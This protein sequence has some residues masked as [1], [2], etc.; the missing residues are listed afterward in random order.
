MLPNRPHRPKAS[1]R[2]AGAARR[3]AE[4]HPTPASRPRPSAPRPRAHGIG[5]RRFSVADPIG[6]RPRRA[7]PGRPAARLPL[8]KFSHPF[9]A[10]RTETSG[11]WGRQ[12]TRAGARNHRPGASMRVV[13]AARRQAPA[14]QRPRTPRGAQN[15][16][17]SPMAMR[18]EA[19]APQ[20]RQAALHNGRPHLRE[21]SAPVAEAAG[22]QAPAPPTHRPPARIPPQGPCNPGKAPGLVGGPHV[23]PGP[24]D[25]RGRGGLQNLFP[26]STAVQGT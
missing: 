3:P 6:P 23:G 20:V 26:G 2:M 4:R 9:P 25:P 8:T 1:E 11:P 19:S 13:G 12:S 5:N 24:A 10:K 17:L 22:R 14:T 15:P 16:R 21:A 18:T 7:W